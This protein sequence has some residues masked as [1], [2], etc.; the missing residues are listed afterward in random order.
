MLTKVVSLWWQVLLHIVGHLEEFSPEALALLPMSLR[1]WLFLNLP[2]ADVCLLEGTSMSNGL[3]MEQIWEELY[4]S[5]LLVVQQDT[6]G[7][8]I[9]FSWKEQYCYDLWICMFDHVRPSFADNPL[10]HVHCWNRQSRRLS[11]NYLNRCKSSMKHILL[12]CFFGASV[13]GSNFQ[14]IQQ[15][16]NIPIFGISQVTCNTCIHVMVCP[17]RYV[18][19]CM[20]SDTLNFVNITS[21]FWMYF[22]H[23]PVYIHLNCDSFLTSCRG[24]SQLILT[25]HPNVFS[26]PFSQVN[27][28]D[29]DPVTVRDDFSKLVLNTVVTSVN[30]NLEMLKID[31]TFDSNLVQLHPLRSSGSMLYGLN[32]KDSPLKRLEVR[33]TNYKEIRDVLIQPLLLNHLTHLSICQCNEWNEMF[34]QLAERF[35][36]MPN[37]RKFSILN[38]TL[39]NKEFNGIF[40]MF[41]SSP[42]PLTLEYLNCTVNGEI[43]ERLPMEEIN[44]FR[45]LLEVDDAQKRLILKL[46]LAYGKI[47]AL[48]LLET[49]PLQSLVISNDL[50]DQLVSL[51]QLN[52]QVLSVECDI[53]NKLLPM[54]LAFKGVGQIELIL[55]LE[56]NDYLYFPYT[57]VQKRGEI[58][59]QFISILDSHQH[60]NLC[61]IGFSSIGNEPLL[62]FLL[63]SV[64]T[65]HYLSD[66]TLDFK[67]LEQCCLRPM[68]DAW[69][70]CARGRKLKKICFKEV[71]DLTMEELSE[72]AEKIE[73]AVFVAGECNQRKTRKMEN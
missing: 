67:N 44:E 30:D 64:M 69:M 24:L 10:N 48:K 4:K 34:S 57:A 15:S 66:L 7:R 52:V 54:I 13:S 3:D 51:K 73:G 50:F 12:T 38:V 8:M 33:S 6:V 26:V 31:L 28:L 29:I 18:H 25:V 19:Q 65:L 53:D 5:R 70:K 62:Y 42:L 39:S 14:A 2:V 16:T 63:E 55:L 36:S 71:I 32:Y 22:H 58:V 17:Q 37:F 49:L 20:I 59:H 21:F 56:E 9:K 41:V 46:K 11:L 72:I 23:K 60:H 43:Q 47:P 45:K 40:A 1:R 27:S 35:F 68:Y 61:S